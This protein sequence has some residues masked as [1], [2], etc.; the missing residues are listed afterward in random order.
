MEESES[1]QKSDIFPQRLNVVI[2]LN[3]SEPSKYA[4]QWSLDNFLDPNKHKLTILT[5]VEPPVQAGY[6]YTAS[7]AIYSPSFFDELHKKALSDATH[8][9]R[10]YQKILE[11]HFNHKMECEMVVARGEVRDEIVDFVEGK[12]VKHS[13]LEGSGGQVQKIEHA[14]ILII[15]KKK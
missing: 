15:G 13:N 11:K 5:V 8:C 14:Q 1:A 3:D 6:Y 2:S 12:L 10:E 4:F 7:A 9:V